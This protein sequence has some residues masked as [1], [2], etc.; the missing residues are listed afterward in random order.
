MEMSVVYERDLLYPT[1]NVNDPGCIHVEVLSPN[2]SGKM[3]Y[4]RKQNYTFT[5]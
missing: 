1:D 2:K 3:P 5:G 4:Y